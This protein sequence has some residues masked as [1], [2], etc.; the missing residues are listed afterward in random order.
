VL[1]LKTFKLNGFA[2]VFK[3]LDTEPKI[4]LLEH[5]NNYSKTLKLI[6]R[7]SKL[8]AALLIMLERLTISL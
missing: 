5:Q 1:C 2:K 6:A 7:M 3:N 8:F 4:I